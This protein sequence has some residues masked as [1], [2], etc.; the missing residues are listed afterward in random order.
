M[1]I[2]LSHNNLNSHIRRKEARLG[3]LEL[4]ERLNHKAKRRHR[5]KHR[6]LPINQVA[7]L[8]L[9]NL[10]LLSKLPRPHLI[11][12]QQGRPHGCSPQL[13]GL[14]LYL[15]TTA[16]C[17]PTPCLPPGRSRSP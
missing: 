4:T 16:I 1:Q 12:S 3:L 5:R 13:L 9:H 2:L 6:G 7:K 14:L 10:G 17:R 8:R 15:S 11:V